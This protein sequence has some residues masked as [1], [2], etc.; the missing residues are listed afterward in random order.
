MTLTEA[1]KT[2]RAFKRKNWYGSFLY[3]DIKGNFP[4]SK[5]DL[6]ADDCE[7]KN[8]EWITISRGQLREAYDKAFSSDLKS[9]HNKFKRMAK[10]LGFKNKEKL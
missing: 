8:E 10:N 9:K 6:L 7:V 2:G 5:E 3:H 4:F 1:V